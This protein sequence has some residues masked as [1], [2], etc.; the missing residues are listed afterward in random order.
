MQ[1]NK[2]STD[3][4]TKL[5]LLLL[6]SVFVL[7]GAG[8][9]GQIMVILRSILAILPVLLLFFEGKRKSVFFCISFYVV[10]YIFQV[11][12]F[13]NTHG[14]INFLFLFS[15]GFFVR[16]L[17]NVMAA[18]YLVSTTTVSELVCAMQKM[19]LSDIFIIPITVMVRF[20]PVA[21]EESSAVS[22][23]M[24]MRGIRFGGKNVFKMLE[25]RFIPMITC[26]VRVGEELSASALARGLA[27]PIKRTNICTIGFH[28]VD[29]FIFAIAAFSILA[30]IASVF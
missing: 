22:D 20:F 4:R 25:Y 6:N 14:L 1:K 19:H 28:V 17:P 2:L 11:T 30:L 21:L 18:Y 7:G 16:I 10:F 15:I 13:E 27:S 26:S 29:F 23:A 24:R 8:G 3:P 9:N 12:I 5:L